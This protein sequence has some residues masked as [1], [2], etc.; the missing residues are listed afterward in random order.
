MMFVSLLVTWLIGAAMT[1]I[2]YKTG[3]WKN[4]AII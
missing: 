1:Y 3:R 4:K 2:V